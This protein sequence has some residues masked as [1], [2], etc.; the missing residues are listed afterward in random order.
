[1]AR[2]ETN[3]SKVKKEIDRHGG[4]ITS[5]ELAKKVKEEGVEHPHSTIQQ[6]ERQGEVELRKDQG[7]KTHGGAVKRKYKRPSA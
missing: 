7:D 5:H 1:M 6:L 4:S 3:V 2:R